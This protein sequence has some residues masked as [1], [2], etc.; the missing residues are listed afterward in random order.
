MS[1]DPRD[2]VASS[3]MSRLQLIAVAICVFLNG[4]DG[5]DVLAISFASPGITEEWGIDRGA[6]GIVLSMELIGMAVGS[7]TLGGM[8]D[9]FGRRPTILGCLIVMSAGML[10]AAFAGGVV[11]LSLIRFITG[12]GIGGMLAAINAMTAEFSNA[13]RRSLSVALMA[14][15]YPMGAIIGGSVAS[16]LLAQFDWRAVFFFGAAVT[17][18]FIP[19]TMIFLPESVSYLAMKRP[20]NALERINRTLRR[21]NKA[22]VDALPP[23]VDSVKQKVGLA[24][25]F[26]PDLRSITLLLTLAYFTHIMTFYY[27]IKWIP[28]IVADMGFDPSLAGSVL[29]WANV[30]GASG[31]LILSLLTQVFDVRKLVVL[32]LML[33]SV[34]V[35]VFGFTD[36]N[37]GQLSLLAALAGICTNS[38]IVGMYA[39]F[40]QYF[41][42]EVRAGGTGF[43]IGVGRGGAALGPIVAGF[44]FEFGHGL[45]TVSFLMGLGSL[46]A[47]AALI[48]LIRLGGQRES[49]ASQPA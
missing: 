47:A 32:A 44:L 46:I 25:L 39:L 45:P 42:T 12:L 10:A 23:V 26:E 43:V 20:A 18:L 9:R 5:F 48:V 14:A 36:S 28:K 40:A 16:M 13:R 2:V 7:V 1:A 19:L 37:L 33:A 30:G 24:K 15:G 11:I 35:V 17:A 34:M 6:L 4:L 3:A 22:P 29:V 31:A 49:P 38:A 41:P 27:I 8:A 21:M